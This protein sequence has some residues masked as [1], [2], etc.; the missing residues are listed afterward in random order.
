MDTSRVPEG[1]RE[2]LG[3]EATVALVE[4]FNGLESE[5]SERVTVRVADRFERRLVEETSRLRVGM[6]EGFA[7]L[8]HE[9]GTVRQEVAAVRDEL[10]QEIRQEIGSVRQEIGSVRQEIAL[11]RFELLKWTFLFWVGQVFAIGSLVTLLL[12]FVRPVG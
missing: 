9:I 1:L 10:R 6:V 5:W 11:N 7:S 8:R 3:F 2:R 4:L 12:R